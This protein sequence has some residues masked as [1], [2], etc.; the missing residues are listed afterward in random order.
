MP[1]EEPS[2]S[3]PSTIVTQAK[4]ALA[5]HLGVVS[6]TLT[7]TTAEARDWSDGAMG[8]PEP[9]TSYI[10][11]IIP[12]YLLIVRDEAGERYAIHTSDT[13]DPLIL[14]QDGMPVPLGSSSSS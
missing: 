5:D 4:S 2:G 12:G 13:A 7:L 11:V 14:C 3:V 10:Q 8:C 6:D 1:P 9:D